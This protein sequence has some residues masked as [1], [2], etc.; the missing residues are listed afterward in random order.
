MASVKVRLAFP[1]GAII[2]HSIGNGY[3]GGYATK[4]WLLVVE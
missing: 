1:S 3:D 2:V 4:N